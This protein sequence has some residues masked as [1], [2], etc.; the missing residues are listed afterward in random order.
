[1][2]K[3]QEMVG[4]WRGGVLEST[5]RGHAVICDGAG[6]IVQSW[7]DPG[8]VIFPRSSSKMIQALALVESGAADAF[9]L[10]Q[11]HLALACASHKG[12][13][14]HVD[15]AGRWLEGIG[16]RES[17]LRCG[18]H[19]PSDREER[20]RLIRAGEAPCQLHNNCSGKHCGFAS[21]AKHI[22]GGPDYTDI[23]HPVQKAARAA[24]EE[25]CA[26]TPAGWGIDGC[27]APNF[28]NSVGA[29]ARAMARFAAA[30]DS[31]DSR[32]RAMHRLTRAMASHPH[33]ISGEG[34]ACTELM[35]AC[36]AGAALKG[37]AEAVYVAILPAR[38]LGIALK[39]EDGNERASQAAL[40]AILVRLGAL[41]AAHPAA[42]RRLPAVQK[43][44]R[45]LVTG[46]LRLAE[47]FAAPG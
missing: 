27:S 45:G 11:A 9:G 34:R 22:G 35:R 15:L 31:G 46:E 16:L 20:H 43:N 18:A 24:V 29:I 1:M 36:G 13:A 39:I 28:A 6:Q 30:Q 33:L 47:G 32:Q 2:V 14:E 8:R 4:L 26:E 38:K 25:T 10:T 12:A 44:W 37:G 23:G 17:D 7:G 21:L 19:E 40:T 3:A 5:H 42:Q 41:D